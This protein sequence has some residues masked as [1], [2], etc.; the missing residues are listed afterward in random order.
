M[1]VNRPLSRR[2]TLLACLVALAAMPLSFVGYAGVRPT[3]VR[4]NSVAR[5][6]RGPVPSDTVEKKKPRGYKKQLFKR[7]PNSNLSIEAI[8]KRITTILIKNME[9]DFRDAPMK[10][11]DLMKDVGLTGNQMKSKRFIIEALQLLQAQ[12]VVHKV[13]QNPARWE[14][15]EE[16]RKYGVPPI[17]RSKRSPWSLT[18]LLQFKRTKAPKFGPAHGLYRPKDRDFLKSRDL[19]LQAIYDP[20]VKPDPYSS[21]DLADLDVNPPRAREVDP[22]LYQDMLPEAPK[23]KDGKFV[24]F[25]QEAGVRR[26]QGV[27]SQKIF[28]P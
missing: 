12:K 27:G 23:D 9:E 1:A 3:Q 26:S 18:H 5:Q 15:H 16:Y 6:A 8:M 22:V 21:G 10:T 20:I 19:P 13:K 4:T 11:V 14:I 28:I 17:S 25:D 24:T 2:T 7:M